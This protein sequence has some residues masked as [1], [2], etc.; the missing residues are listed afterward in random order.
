MRLV[1]GQ[2]CLQRVGLDIADEDGLSV[3]TVTDLPIGS[4][5]ECELDSGEPD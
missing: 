2:H 1:V 3:C 5:L 4:S